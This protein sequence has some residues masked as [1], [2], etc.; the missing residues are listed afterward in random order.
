MMSTPAATSVASVRENRAIVIFLIV[1]PICSGKCRQRR[2]QTGRPRL[3]FF[4]RKKPKIDPPQSGKTMNQSCRSRFEAS[5]TY[6]VSVGSW[7]FS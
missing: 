2:S 4:Q 7:P 1:S 3:L 5:R 6:W